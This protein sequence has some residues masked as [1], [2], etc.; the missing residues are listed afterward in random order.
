MDVQASSR[1]PL[2][3]EVAYSQELRLVAHLL[4]DHR[5]RQILTHLREND[6]SYPFRMELIFAVGILA[7][8]AVSL[9][10]AIART[11]P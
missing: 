8:L 5:P 7:L 10:T 11:L 6:P 9:G 1:C 2:C 3:G 4:L